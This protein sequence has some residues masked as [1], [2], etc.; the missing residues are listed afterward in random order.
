MSVAK[1]KSKCPYC[2]ETIAVGATKCKHCQSDLPRK[3]KWFRLS[4][5]NTFRIGFAVGVL[6][7]LA[8][9][10]LAWIQFYA[11]E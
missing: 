11:G 1:Q 2:K 10:I 5:W 7:T 9:S 3:R 8:L 6:F 4:R